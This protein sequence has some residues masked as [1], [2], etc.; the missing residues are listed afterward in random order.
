MA[1]KPLELRELTP[2]EREAGERAIKKAKTVAQNA[3]KV[4]PLKKRKKI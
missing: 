3:V 1:L 2:E 4:R